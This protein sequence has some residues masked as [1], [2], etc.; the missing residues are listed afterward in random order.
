V[1][2][3]IE[4]GW[5]AWRGIATIAAVRPRPEAEFLPLGEAARWY[6]ISEA[7]VYR[8]LTDAKLKRYRREGDRRTWLSVEEL[9]SLLRP[10]PAG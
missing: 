1:W 4:A 6:G 5:Q 7:T 8:L 2:R 10:R 9:E 3:L